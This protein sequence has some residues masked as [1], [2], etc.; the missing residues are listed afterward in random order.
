MGPAATGGA[1]AGGKVARARVLYGVLCGV[2]YGVPYGVLKGY[3]MG[4]STGHSTG[5][6]TGHSSW[7]TD[8]P[9]RAARAAVA[10][11]SDRP[12]RAGGAGAANKQTNHP[13]CEKQTNKQRRG[14]KAS[15]PTARKQMNTQTHKQTNRSTNAQRGREPARAQEDESGL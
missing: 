7:R 14:T 3:S 2:P 5:Y 13:R 12:R 10:R 1:A 15:E 6:S 11:H 8:L 4:Y 9:G